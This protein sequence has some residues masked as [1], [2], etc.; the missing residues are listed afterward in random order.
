MKSLLLNFRDIAMLGGRY[1]LP[2]RRGLV[3]TS[4]AAVMKPLDAPPDQVYSK[5]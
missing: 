5:C 3:P 4:D 2:H 1:P